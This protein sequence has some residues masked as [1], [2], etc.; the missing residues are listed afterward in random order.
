MKRPLAVL[1]AAI[2]AF[3]MTGCAEKETELLELSEYN[4]RN[5]E[6][7]GILS[8]ENGY[9]VDE[10]G[11]RILLR[12]INL[13]NWMLM[14]TWMNVVPEY[15]S[16]WAHYD[17]LELLTERFGEEKTAELMR[18]YQENFITE[19]DIAQIEKLGFNCVR[20]PFWYRNFMNEDGSWLTENAEE[21]PGFQTL[22]WLIQQCGQ[23]G[24]YV[25]LDLHGAP[26]GQSM[27][28][29]CGKAGRNLL[30]TVEENM[31]AAIAQRYKDSPVVAAYD[32]LNEPQNNGG[33]TGETAWAAESEEAV[34]HTNAAY[35]RLYKAVRGVDE[36]HMISLEGVWSTTVLPDPEEMG[37][38]N[39]LYQL[40]LYDTE[41]GMIRYRVNELKK[42][43][44][45]WNVA[46]IVGEFNNHAEE[47][48]ACK[49]Y[50]QNDISYVKWTYKTMN[51]GDNWG[52]FNG[53]VG[54]I[55][56]MYASYEQIYTFFE[57]NLSTE[58]YIFNKEE[59]HVIMP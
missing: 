37:Y 24:I 56:L 59:M 31:R 2:M 9:I 1:M 51:T 13:G 43:R 17:T 23:H 28:H 46:V 34:T 27:N 5:P 21:N 30:Y 50:V 18:E 41:K 10:T 48:Y 16:D 42:A 6:I 32:L 20:I 52:I 47:S 25:I 4:H 57:N 7:T 3:S 22:D 12:G 15:T 19:A 36:K 58:N 26:G 39:M 29:G 14:E 33:Y 45:N 35:D 44:R 53:N 49:K 11:R 40:H 54:D 55:D 8:V 38:E